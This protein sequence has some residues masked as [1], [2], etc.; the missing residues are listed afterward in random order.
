MLSIL[1]INNSLAF[2]VHPNQF[3]VVTDPGVEKNIF[4][5]MSYHL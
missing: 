3:F 1:A 5:A 4:M 2:K